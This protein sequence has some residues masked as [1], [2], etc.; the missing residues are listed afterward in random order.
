MG[1]RELNL[2]L[3]FASLSRS[4]LFLESFYEMGIHPLFQS[5]LQNRSNAFNNPYREGENPD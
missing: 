3:F 1:I 4:F 5:N 2:S